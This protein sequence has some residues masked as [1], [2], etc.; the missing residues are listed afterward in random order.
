MG[1]PVSIV[2]AN[3]YMEWWEQTALTTCPQLRL[4]LWRR[5]VGDCYEKTKQG[6]SD[7]FTEHPNQVD[8]TGNIKVMFE[9][10]FE[11]ALPMLDTESYRAEGGS[12]EVIVY[13]KKTHTDQYLN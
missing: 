1:I 12:L 5:Y 4:S 11:G 3:L 10:E 6:T 2:V 7:R 13:R 9:G 8:P